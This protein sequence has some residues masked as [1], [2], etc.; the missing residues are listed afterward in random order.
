MVPPPPSFPPARFPEIG[1]SARGTASW[2]AAPM[3]LQE[4]LDSDDSYTMH[5]TKQMQSNGHLKI[6]EVFKKARIELAKASGNHQI[7]QEYGGLL[8][9]FCLGNCQEN[10]LE[11]D[12]K[13]KEQELADLKRKLAQNTINPDEIQELKKRLGDLE[14]K[15]SSGMSGM[16]GMVVEKKPE[17]KV[18][19][20]F[21]DC[22][23]C[24]EMVFLAGGA[25]KMGDEK[26]HD[27][28]IKAFAI[29]KFEVTKGQFAKFVEKIRLDA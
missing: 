3:T 27:V 20:S 6:E 5:L 12:L 13:A 15:A 14:K 19:E 8:G 21:R 28:E 16:S 4:A 11:K 25:F 22:S 18:G 17:P 2:S 23:D 29:G 9:D 26:P 24:P 1:R 7:S 10:T